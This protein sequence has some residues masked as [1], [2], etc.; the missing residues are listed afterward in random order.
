MKRFE[1]PQ[2]SKNYWEVIYS[3]ER[4]NCHDKWEISDEGMDTITGKKNVLIEISDFKNLK[5]KHIRDFSFNY[6]DFM[7]K[8]EN[9]YL[10]FNNC[11][12]VECSFYRSS[13]KNIKFQKCNFENT[14]FSITKFENC[15][16]RECKFKDISISGNEMKF[17][18]S[19]IEPYK[20]I[21]AAYTNLDS[22]ILKEKNINPKYQLYRLEGTKSSAARM[23]LQ[24]RPIKNDIDTFM[25][26]KHI[27]RKC[28]S[29]HNIKK[30]FY[31]FSCKELKTKFKG[32]LSI[33]LYFIEYLFISAIGWLSGWGLKA[34]RTLIIGL[35]CTIGFSFYYNFF[36]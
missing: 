29:F 31:Q 9:T 23:L 36:L 21:K 17:L 13:W 6:V 27:A 20:F 34:G 4:D 30:G 18:N 8:L 10:N 7:G 28:E 11:N 19:Y 3:P 2:R 22:S 24:M 26:A 35:L 12:F 14:S 32:L 5:I 16:F 25:D 33:L 1:N 15:E